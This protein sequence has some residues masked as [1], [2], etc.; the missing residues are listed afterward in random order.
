MQS[1]LRAIK[2][3]NQSLERFLDQVQGWKD[4][5]EESKE[6]MTTLTEDQ[7][8]VKA[9]AQQVNTTVALRS[10]T[11][12]AGSK[13]LQVLTQFKTYTLVCFST[14]WIDALQRKADEETLVL[15][16]LTNDWQ[17]YTKV[18]SAIKSNTSTTTQNMRF[19]QNN[20][21]VDQQRITMASEVFY[22]LTQQ[23]MASGLMLIKLIVRANV[24]DLIYLQAN[25]EC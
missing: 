7:E 2:I 22:D 13:L 15:Q 19:L 18:L 6:K 5:I 14:M 3:L 9:I 10:A 20:I 23:V 4:V 16:K 21:Q 8:D 17:N 11:P 25:K 24:F 1:H 12:S